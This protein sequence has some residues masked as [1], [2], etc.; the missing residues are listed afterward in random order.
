MCCRSAACSCMAICCLSLHLKPQTLNVGSRQRQCA[1]PKRHPKQQR[2]ETRT[3]GTVFL[4][5]GATCLRLPPPPPRTHLPPRPRPLHPQP[6]ARSARRRHL[7]QHPRVCTRH[8]HMHMLWH[9]ALQMLRAAQARAASSLLHSPASSSIRTL[10]GA[11]ICTHPPPLPRKSTETRTLL[12]RASKTRAVMYMARML[13]TR[14]RPHMI[15]HVIALT[16]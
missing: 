11:S 4:T 13:R 2:A 9:Q 10:S 6:R 12:A 16:R 15:G 1:Q 14:R 8:M 3:R 5:I 7:G